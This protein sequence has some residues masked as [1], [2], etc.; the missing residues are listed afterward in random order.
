MGIVCWILMLFHTL[1]FLKIKKN[2]AKCVVCFSRDG[3]F[4]G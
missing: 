2:V 1:F 3:R 4:K